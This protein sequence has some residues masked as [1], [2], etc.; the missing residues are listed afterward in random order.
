MSNAPIRV[1]KKD[2]VHIQIECPDRSTLAEL[3]ERFEFY[4]SGYNFMPAF[5]ARKWDGKI[6]L[7][8]TRNNTLYAGLFPHVCAFAQE[9]GYDIEIDDSNGV[10]I[11][12]DTV[13]TDYLDA[14]PM[15][16]RGDP[17]SPREYQREAVEYALRHRRALLLSPTAS[18][19][20]LIIYMIVRYVLYHVQKPVL[21]V[22]PTTSLVRQMI[23]DF[24]DYASEDS[25]FN[26]S[27]DCHG[28]YQGQERDD[29]SGI[30]VV[31]STWQSIYQMPKKWFSQF[32][33][34]VGDEA[35][36]FKA[37]SL[38]AI[39]GKMVNTEYR[40]GTTGTLD[41][42][43]TNQLVLEGIFGP[44]KYV[45]TT[46]DLMD[47]GALA[48]L[49]VHMHILDYPSQIRRQI[50]GASYHEEIDFLV[51]DMSRNQWIVDLA[52]SLDGN[53]LVLFQYV[54]K[55][56]K[57][58]FKQ[59]RE[60]IDPNRKAFYVSGETDTDTREE[61]RQITEREG[62]AIIVAS[63]GTF[64]T[65]INIRNIHNIVFASPSKSQIRILQS[66]GRGLRVSDDGRPTQVYDIAD[67]LHI[68]EGYRNYTLNHA[69][70][71]IKIYARERFEYTINQVK[72]GDTDSNE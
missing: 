62:S 1:K 11:A 36:N 27:V 7:F 39:M 45:T 10:P 42:S 48:Q 68:G 23:S 70:E 58:L 71:R 63:L 4:A 17:I 64:S 65:G 53:T 67:D 29:V 31:V 61:I 16:S 9:N 32:G 35:H 40:I 46:R 60:A 28:I 43:E 18:G 14:L 56:G 72:L 51:G 52:A 15:S 50:K 6:R 34:V 5:K 19:K 26:P 47:S 57:P 8:N 66:I 55:H 38:T 49:K 54:D 20:S 41:G 12:T 69:S 13:D 2:S 33:C 25:D 30:P 22:V 21:I 24:E 3:S 37:K 44:L 59:I